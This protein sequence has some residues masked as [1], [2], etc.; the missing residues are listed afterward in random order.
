MSTGTTARADRIA[1]RIV[2]R[3]APVQ[4]AASAAPAA[5]RYVP[6]PAGTPAP[7]LAAVPAP[8]PAPSPRVEVSPPV[9]P[10]PPTPTP[11][12]PPPPDRGRRPGRRLSAVLLGFV[13]GLVVGLLGVAGMV[14]VVGWPPGP[15][16]A[17]PG[18]APAPVLPGRLAAAF[19]DLT[20]LG[21]ACA[22]YPPGADEYVTS[23]GARPVAVVRC[24][25][26]AAVPGGFVYYAEWP[27]VADALR[28]QADQVQW[29]PSVDGAVQWRDGGGQL[30]GPWHTRAAADGTVYATAAYSERP[31]T[32][33]VVT[34]SAQDSQRM[35]SV[36]HLRPATEVPG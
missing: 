4:P 19:P 20:A 35:R 34:R 1:V 9:P 2:S 11:T 17:A 21:T 24:D 31:Y 12:P 14:A 26:G 23:T 33:D 22:A 7:G 27:T 30:Q 29:G 3:A 8:R 25:H 13:I 15:D 28:W 32:F 5:G 10:V 36:L 16:R 18:A 6:V